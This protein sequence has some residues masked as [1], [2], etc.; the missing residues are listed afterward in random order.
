MLTNHFA[1]F[2]LFILIYYFVMSNK[3]DSLTII[4]N[5]KLSMFY[6]YRQRNILDAL[7]TTV[8]RLCLQVARLQI[9]RH[10]TENVEQ[11]KSKYVMDVAQAQIDNNLFIKM[12]G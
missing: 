9:R 4:T 5:Q 10:Q 8:P 12:K 7:K 2:T 11:E 3:R 6:P 1:Y